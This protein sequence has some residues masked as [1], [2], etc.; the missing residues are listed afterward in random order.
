MGI[1]HKDKQIRFWGQEVEGQGHSMT[2][3]GE[4][5]TLGGAF[6]YLSPECM[7]VL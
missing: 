5:S 6:C 1:G 7:D 3:Y 2:T 4:I